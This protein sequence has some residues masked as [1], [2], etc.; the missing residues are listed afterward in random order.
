MVENSNEDMMAFIEGVK[1][2]RGN[3]NE[4]LVIIIHHTG[5]DIT[6]GSRGHSS[7][8]AALDIE[9]TVTHAESSNLTTQTLTKSKDSEMYLKEYWQR[10]VPEGAN[11]IVLEPTSGEDAS[12]AD[13]ER[14]T[15]RKV[16]HAIRDICEDNEGGATQAGILAACPDL[17]KNK[18][19]AMATT[20][21]N[22]GCI[23]R[24]GQA[25]GSRYFYVTDRLS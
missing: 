7:F 8:Y 15:L 1:K 25:G 17:N 22:E 12:E 24:E 21:R 13:D 10:R 9:I 23:R 16:L 20:L 6:R 4:R 2:I 3:N 5:K 19:A 14:S 18:W 11:S